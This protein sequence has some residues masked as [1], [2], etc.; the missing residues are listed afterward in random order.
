M[1]DFDHMKE[2]IKYKLLY[3]EQVSIKSL[4][5]AVNDADRLFSD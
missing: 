2:I 1:C 4:L 5:F 3:K